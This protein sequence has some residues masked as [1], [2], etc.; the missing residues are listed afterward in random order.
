MG[1]RSNTAQRRVQITQ[2]MLQTMA[3]QGYAK[4][5]V[6]KIARV[7]GLTP[8][9]IHYHFKTK[10]EILV[11]LIEQLHQLGEAR[12]RRLSEHADSP[13]MRFKAF[14]DAHLAL[15]PDADKHAVASW[16]VIAAEAVRQE[17]VRTLFRALTAE[18]LRHL[19]ELLGS[20]FK[21]RGKSAD[22]VPR[23][24]AA[25]L[26]LIEGAFQLSASAADVLPEGFAAETTWQLAMRFLELE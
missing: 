23:L 14:L 25:L 2:A 10:Q 19:E 24:A 13:E 1:R 26:S 22:A 8:G 18:R 12:F 6:Q 15:G 7:A 11:A 16:V 3:E 5:T 17:E 21:H 4:A 20:V 9:L